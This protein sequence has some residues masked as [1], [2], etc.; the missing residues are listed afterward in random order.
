LIFDHF[1][2][3]N[4][5]VSHSQVA[6]NFSTFET[7]FSNYNQL[8][9]TFRSGV[10]PNKK[11]VKN[12]SANSQQARKKGDCGIGE[13]GGEQDWLINIQLRTNFN[14]LSR[15]ELRALQMKSNEEA[16]NLINSQTRG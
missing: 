7:M 2:A 15:G 9:R 6:S 3:L 4:A 13:R 1:H 16:P 10:L 12:C 8:L 5:L 14:S 11:L